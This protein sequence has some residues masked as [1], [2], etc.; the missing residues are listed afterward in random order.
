MVDWTVDLMFG[1][2]TS[3]LGQLGHPPALGMSAS[4]ME[5]TETVSR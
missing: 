1:R 2:D 5:A 3:E 4:G